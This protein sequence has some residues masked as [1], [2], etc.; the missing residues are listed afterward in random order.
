ME[1]LIGIACLFIGLLIGYTFASSN[2]HVLSEENSLAKENHDDTESSD[3][4][5]DIESSGGDE[6]SQKEEEAIQGLKHVLLQ[7]FDSLSS[8]LDELQH[9]SSKYEKDLEAQKHS[10]QQSLSL[11]DLKVLGDELLTHVSSMHISNTRYRH[12]LSAANELVKLQQHE[13]KELQIKAGTDFLTDTHNR[14][15]LDEH[16]RVMINICRRYGNIFSL[17]VLDIDHFKGVNDTL[18]HSAGDSV[19]REVAEVLKKQSRESDFLARYG[20]EEFVYVLPEMSAPEALQMAEKLLKQIEEHEFK[21]N[22]EDISITVSAG[23]SEVIK[24]SD[25][26]ESIFKR[27]DKALFNAKEGGRN[28]VEVE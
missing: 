1:I 7:L 4:I 2:K 17:L 12:Q 28:R 5:I 6:E 11:D 13:L 22:D 3:P 27:A 10:L 26:R 21:Y 18:G 14:S 15:A 25:D 24:D 9:D 19:L 23:I 20:G 16:L 8:A